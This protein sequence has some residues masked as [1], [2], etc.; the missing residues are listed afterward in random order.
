M[1]C[2]GFE[3]ALPRSYDYVIGNRPQRGVLTTILTGPE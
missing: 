3:P 2:A 1:S